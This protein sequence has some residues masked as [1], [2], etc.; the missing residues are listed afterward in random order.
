MNVPPP[1]QKTKAPPQQT[2]A[3]P[4]FYNLVMGVDPGMTGAIAFYD[5]TTKKLRAVYDTPLIAN[6]NYPAKSKIKNILNAGKL[7]EIIAGYAQHTALVV[8]EEVSAMPNDGPVQAFRF[9][10]VTGV[11]RGIVVAHN[12]PVLKIR[13]AV[14][15]SLLG[16]KSDKNLSLDLARKEFK[17]NDFFTLKKHNGRAEAALLAKLG[18]D[19][20]IKNI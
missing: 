16:L 8:I 5:F 7:A 9:G 18:A 13:P 20:F 2:K 11:V 10:F 6:P 15:K 14:W 19:R 1:P 12:I 3:P 17:N 4:P